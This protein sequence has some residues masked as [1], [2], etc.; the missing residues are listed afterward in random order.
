[1]RIEKV[2]LWSPGF[3]L[4]CIT[5]NGTINKQGA[6]VMGKGC[7]REANMRFGLGKELGDRIK[8]VGNVVQLFP[9]IS[10]GVN[11]ATFPVK[12]NWW[13]KADLA[14]I[15][16]SAVQLQILIDD[17]GFT[18]VA[19]PMP[20]CGNGGLNWKDVAGVIGFLDDRVIVVH[21]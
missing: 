12:H 20:G 5:T 3:D 15:G 16:R 6:C 8:G 19:L 7:A 14:L 10:P 9:D 11:L 21:Q 4:R 1:M 2:D 13:E 17:W 18:K